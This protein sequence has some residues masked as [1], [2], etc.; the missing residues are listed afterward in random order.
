MDG[1]G[2]GEIQLK[3]SSLLLH[4][5]LQTLGRF[6]I[7]SVPRGLFVYGIAV[8]NCSSIHCHMAGTRNHVCSCT[9]WSATG[10]HDR[11]VPLHC[12]FSQEHSRVQPS[13]QGI[14]LF[15]TQLKY[16]KRFRAF[17]GFL[18]TFLFKNGGGK[19]ITEICSCASCS[20]GR[21]FSCCL[22][23]G[24]QLG[25]TRTHLCQPPALSSCPLPFPAAPAFQ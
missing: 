23:A 7:I 9:H 24:L 4:L 18:L 15:F 20:Q 6:G 10:I 17:E 8:K 2:K 13:S 19:G 14:R 1:K 25:F 22:H 16:E 5:L 12:S 3:T 21:R 11:H